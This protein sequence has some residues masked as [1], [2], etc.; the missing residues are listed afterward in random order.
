MDAFWHAWVCLGA[1][2]EGEL[3]VLAA[4]FAVNRGWL[5]GGPLPYV[6][7]AGAFLGD[8]FFFELGRRKGEAWLEDKP[9]TRRLVSS[10]SGFLAKYSWGALFILRFQIACRMAG[11]FALGA[12]DLGRGRYLALNGVACALWAI[13]IPKLCLFFWKMMIPMWE[14][15]WS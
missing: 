2:A 8:W 13:A 5:S 9:K 3:T 6:A 10:V 7:F 11:N 15:A 4:A 1:F 14:R 12:G